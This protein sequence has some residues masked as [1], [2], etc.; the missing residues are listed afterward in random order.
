MK[1]YV[2]EDNTYNKCYVVQN[3]GVIRGYDRVP[4]NNTNYNYRDYYVKSDYM[5][6][7][8]SGTWSSYTTLP[9]CLSSD[10][11]TNDYWYRLDITSVLIN[12]T[13]I[14]LFG[15]YFPWRIFKSLFGR[16]FL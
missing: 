8:G 12:V 16:R 13:I 3:E 11:L 2:P 7:D 4:S 14:S 15:L 6:R 5:F 9:T 1:I 10:I